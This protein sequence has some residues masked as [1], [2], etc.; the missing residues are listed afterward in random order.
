MPR[1]SD[2]LY[3]FRPSGA[4]GS[5]AAAGVPADRAH[6]LAAELDPV[7][8]SLVQTER[9]CH[10]VVE[11]GRRAAALIRAR[12]TAAVESILATAAPKAAG[13]RS[14]ARTAAYEA[15]AASIAAAEAAA[16]DQT[17]LL[18]GRLEQLLP[19]LLEQ[20]SLAVAGLVEGSHG[21]AHGP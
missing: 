6:D 4:P 10:E 17:P 7:F 12:D 8:A 13:E 9:Q 5:A 3:R 19:Q 16:D 11:E 18:R 1:V 2:L 20:V 21:S 15:G 14:R